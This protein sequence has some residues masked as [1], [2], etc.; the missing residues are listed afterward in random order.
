MEVQT[1]ME[2]SSVPHDV[3]A[4]QLSSPTDSMPESY[5]NSES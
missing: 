2:V 1:Q 3:P 4:N 5:E